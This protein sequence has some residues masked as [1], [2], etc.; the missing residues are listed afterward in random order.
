MKPSFYQKVYDVVRQIP[1]GKVLTYKQ[2]ATLAGNPKASR[3]VG[4][5]M[6]NNP[7]MKT[8]PCHRVVGSDG[9]MRGYAFG[10][11]N[12][13]IELLKKEGIR[14][15]GEYLDVVSNRWQSI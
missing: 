14:F 11:K 4:T 9:K 7:D 1:P 15:K 13:K 8:I 12:K 2:V 3:A 5:A 6:K 10:G